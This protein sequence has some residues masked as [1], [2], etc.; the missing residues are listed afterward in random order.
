MR[1]ITLSLHMLP[2][3]GTYECRSGILG[4]TTNS[5]HPD[6]LPSPSSSPSIQV[7]ASGNAFA[8][9]LYLYLLLNFLSTAVHDRYLLFLL[10]SPTFYLPSAHINMHY[11]QNSFVAFPVL[12]PITLDLNQLERSELENIAC[13]LSLEIP[14][15]RFRLSDIRKFYEVRNWNVIVIHRL[16]WIVSLWL[17]QEQSKYS[18]NIQCDGSRNMESFLVATRESSKSMHVS[19]EILYLILMVIEYMYSRF[20]MI[21]TYWCGPASVAGPCG[22][23]HASW[24]LWYILCKEGENI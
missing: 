2:L 4:T 7:S 15:T 18:V 21:Q 17:S 19:E 8:H 11:E 16:T 6:T 10:Y 24:F 13:N 3:R 5:V 20:H 22:L 9:S 14:N 1:W 23:Y 12:R